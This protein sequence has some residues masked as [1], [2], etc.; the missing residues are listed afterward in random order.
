MTSPQTLTVRVARKVLDAQD[1]VQLDLVDP[2]GRDL[3]PFTAG[4]HIEVELTGRDG[5]RVRRPYS[6]CNAPGDPMCYQ[7]A[8]LREPESRG[9][10]Q[11]V[12]ESVQE[13][14]LLQI[15]VPKNLFALQPGATR[16]LLLAGGIGVTPLLS[17]AEQL[18]AEG[19]AF[20]LHYATRNPERTAFQMRIANASYAAQVQFHFDEGDAVQRLDLDAVLQAP[21]AGDHLYVCGPGGFME[22]VLRAARAQGWA[23]AQLHHESFGAVAQPITAQERFEVK[24]G[25]AGRL[26]QVS[27]GQTVTQALADAGVEIMVSCEQGVCGTCLTRVI[28]GVPEHRD[29]YLTAEERAVNDQFLPCCSRSLTPTLVL[30]L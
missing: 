29:S 1:I 22:A 21:A 24:L 16:S 18:S 12:H 25:P 20:T 27:P 4:A 10:S 14:D 17:M 13:G 9:G 2:H 26:I 11:A 30:D 15:S 7:I 8:V 28:D 23:E 19:A 3:P 5:S 6:L